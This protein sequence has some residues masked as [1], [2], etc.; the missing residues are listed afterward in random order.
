MKKS[1]QMTKTFEKITQN[2][3]LNFVYLLHIYKLT[4]CFQLLQTT[5]EKLLPSTEEHDDGYELSSVLNKHVGPIDCIVTNRQKT[6]TLKE[7]KLLV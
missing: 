6:V 7:I 5:I 2:A 3:R 1:K 4:L